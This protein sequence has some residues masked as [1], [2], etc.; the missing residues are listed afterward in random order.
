ML[1]H[2]QKITLLKSPVNAGIIGN[3]SAL[4]EHAQA[5]YILF[6]DADD[7]WLPEKISKTMEKMHALES[8]HGG[9]VPLLVH[10]DLKIVDAQLNTIHPSFWKYSHL[11]PS[12]PHTLPRQLIQNQITGCTVMI[13]KA[14]ADLAKPI[15][16]EALMHDWWLGL[17]TAAFG[18]MDFVSEPTMLYR[19]HGKNDTGAKKYGF[20]PFFKRLLS[21]DRN[22]LHQARVKNHQQATTFF[23]RYQD[24]LNQQQKNSIQGFLQFHHASFFK[25]GYLMVKWGIYR[26][27]FLRNVL[28]FLAQHR[29][30]R[31]TSM[32]H[33]KIKKGL[34]IPIKGKPEGPVQ[35]II[36][37]GEASPL[38]TPSFV[39]LNLSSF[40]DV[41]FHLMVSQGDGSKRGSPW[42]R[43]NHAQGECSPR[44]PVEGS[45]K[46]GAD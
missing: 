19:Q 1:Q 23:T 46:S 15:P 44:L 32:A 31:S 34:N 14:L 8:L 24:R 25:K 16:K 42:Q 2:P 29:F 12:L 11:R 27:G 26:T 43:T 38:K 10:T 37:G 3:F 39:S 36:P 40:D 13:N 21:R 17:C 22:E 4:L 33:I 6:S 5:D 9:H 41:K 7:V 30:S 28:F 45:M 18:K 35:N 20:L